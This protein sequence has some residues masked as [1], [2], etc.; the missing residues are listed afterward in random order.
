V[1][2]VNLK[3][4][5][6]FGWL[7]CEKCNNAV[8]QQFN[9]FECVIIKVIPILAMQFTK[10][11]ANNHFNW[12]DNALLIISQSP[13]T[14]QTNIRIPNYVLNQGIH[15]I[16]RM[17]YNLHHASA[18][19]TVTYWEIRGPRVLSPLITLIP[20][21]RA[22]TNQADIESDSN[23]T[24]HEFSVW[25]WTNRLASQP[26]PA[27]IIVHISH[28][29]DQFLQQVQANRRAFIVRETHVKE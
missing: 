24:R 29:V 3:G 7:L 12:S 4:T 20:R 5:T 19:V 28:V 11:D 22:R 21:S 23:T 27:V 8:W 1:N 6:K 9:F 16:F 10:S 13:L 2:N 26:S 25:D 14:S 17:F 15:T 18:R